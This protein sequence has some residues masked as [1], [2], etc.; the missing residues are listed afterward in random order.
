MSFNLY[1]GD[2]HNHCS[3]SYGHGTVK[4]AL[5]R[6]RQQLDFCSITGHAFWPDMPTDRAVYAEIIDYHHE[7]FARLARNWASLLKQQAEAAREGEFVV[8]PSYEW[9]SRAY[10]DHNVYSMTPELALRDAPDLPA[11]R[12]V[13]RQSGALTI[14]HHIGYAAGYRGIDWDHFA[15]ERSPF[16]EI[17]SLHGCSVAERAPLPMLHDMG[18]RDAGSTAEEGWRRGFKFGIVGCTDHH[19]GYPGSH[20]DGR[21]GV[22]AKG[23]TRADLWEAFRARRVYAATGD[24]IDARLFVDGAWIG[25]TIHAPGRRRLKLCVRALDSI[26][27]VEVLKNG[28][29]L[30]RLF[31][32][33]AAEPSG[34]AAYR[35]RFTWGWGL[36]KSPV[37]WDLGLTLSEGELGRV[38]SGFSGQAVVSPKA[39][40]VNGDEEVPDDEDLPH[41]VLEATA[42][43]VRWRS[44]TAG[45]LSMRHGTMQELSV[46]LTAPPGAKVRVECNGQRF[47]HTLEELRFGGRAHYL[48]GWRSEALRI[49]P[50]VPKGECTV[51]AEFEDEPE[52]ETDVYRLQAGQ[53]N[54][55]W[56]WLT[57]VWAGR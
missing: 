30:R 3:V 56:V 41:E 45:N 13:A 23:L 51:E 44:V 28:R 47:E 42:K 36:K 35:L 15:E 49:G 54:G 33:P 9:H 34:A 6:A 38:D 40:A 8:F 11:L 53:H 25:E 52:R 5:L 18:P 17:Y 1:W 43:A 46:E 27:L 55:Q 4:Q 14:P 21:M 2:L 22:F 10:G 29:V 20:G 16:V 48:R 19:A 31:P 50:L 57:P 32:A 26:Q 24:K 7:G 12:E 39:G 37:R